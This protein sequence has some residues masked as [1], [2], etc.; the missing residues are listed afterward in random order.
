LSTI[1]TTNTYVI[2]WTSSSQDPK[3]VKYD[4]MENNASRQTVTIMASEFPDY[5]TDENGRVL[6]VPAA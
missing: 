3:C 6:S 1:K 2:S 5:F 4:V